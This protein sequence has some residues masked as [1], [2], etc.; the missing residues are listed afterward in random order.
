[1]G[2]KNLPPMSD[3]VAAEFKRLKKLV[4]DGELTLEEGK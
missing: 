2:E 4:D 3:E 1:M